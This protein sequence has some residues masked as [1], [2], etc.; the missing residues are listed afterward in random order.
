M[1]NVGDRVCSKIVTHV[2]GTVT[3]TFKWDVGVHWDDNAEANVWLGRD[4]R[5]QRYGDLISEEEFYKS[6]N[7]R[8]ALA[9]LL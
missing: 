1:L 3:L 7:I 4:N 2:R 8:S 9:R 5:R 6:M